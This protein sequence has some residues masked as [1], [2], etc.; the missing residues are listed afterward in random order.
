VDLLG[1]RVRLRAVEEADAEAMAAAVADPDVARFAGSS[2]LPPTSVDDIRERIRAGRDHLRWTVIAREDEA[3]VGSTALFR[4]DHRDR[5]CWWSIAL[6]PPSRWDRGYGTE[7]CRLVTRFAFRQLGMEKVYL[8]VFEGNDRGRRAYERA[9]FRVEGVLR[10]HILHAG[11]LIDS[12]L[13]AAYRDD[14]I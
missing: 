7:T 11:R 3:N 12:Y 8:G 10:R 1:D 4:I 5:H 9:G 6:A 2:F 13:M 14:R